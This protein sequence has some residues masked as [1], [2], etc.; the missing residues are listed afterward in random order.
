[1][2]CMAAHAGVGLPTA[3]LPMGMQTRWWLPASGG[4][5]GVRQLHTS[6]AV[7]EQAGGE[8]AGGALGRNTSS[9]SYRGVSR[10]T[11][12]AVWMARLWDP[13]AK[14]QNYVGTYASEVDAARAY[15]WAAV[16]M[17]GP[18]YIER[19]FPGELISE[20]PVSLGDER[21][22]RKTSR[23]TG[24]CWDKSNEAWKAQLWNLQTKRRQGIGYYASEQ[25]AARAYDYAAV[26]AHGPGAVRNFPGEASDKVPE[27]VV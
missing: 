21:R 20:P 19:N 25:D 4:G 22:E 10:D 18:E 12:D 27:A 14:R 16:K 26:Q 3:G 15:D 5:G 9:S 17:H 2:G 23:F 8:Q 24:V 7:G 13:E 6:V 11:R 1:M